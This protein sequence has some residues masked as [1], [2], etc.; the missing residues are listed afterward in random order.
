VLASCGGDK[1]GSAAGEP[2]RPAAAATAAPSAT[3]AGF[4][5]ARLQPALMG[6]DRITALLGSF[7]ATRDK[8][9]D[10]TLPF[11]SVASIGP[12]LAA[13]GVSLL[14]N[15]FQV[16]AAPAPGRP[17]TVQNTVQGYPTVAGST[18]AFTALRTAW[19]GNLFQNLQPQAN[20]GPAWRESFCQLGNFSVS[21][22]TGQVQ[23]QQ[24]YVC[25]G[26]IGP[27]VVTVSVGAINMLDAPSVAPVVKA[28]FDQA[29][30][31]LQ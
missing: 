1:A 3:P 15:S 12:I 7:Q 4:N 22:A 10:A 19:Q 9:T 29:A 31:S 8:V 11:S 25:M 23:M 18:A 21:S 2:T 13:Q 20:A 26:L 5:P 27:Y 17:F 28:Y 16:T 6:A 24:W 30:Q 14:F